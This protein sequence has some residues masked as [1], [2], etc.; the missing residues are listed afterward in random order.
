MFENVSKSILWDVTPD[1]VK[2]RDAETKQMLV[3]SVQRGQTERFLMSCGSLV[4]EL[5]SD[6]EKGFYASDPLMV[7]FD[8]AKPDEGMLPVLMR[9]YNIRFADLS[10][11]NVATIRNILDEIIHAWRLKGTDA[12]LYWILGKLFG[13]RLRST[14]T[15]ASSVLRCSVNGCT[16]YD[17][18]ISWEEQMILY[19]ET[20]LTPD[21]KTTT[22][23]DVQHDPDF[24]IKKDL[25]ETMMLDWGYPR[26]FQF[27]NT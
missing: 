25:L 24:W 22:V 20:Q 15:L 3:D 21:D 27:I 12:F 6:I 7:D 8:P 10:A 9:R 17:P 18:D 5:F 26:V 19:D 1:A 13:W 2:T 14:I 16:L 4:T 11:D 23:I